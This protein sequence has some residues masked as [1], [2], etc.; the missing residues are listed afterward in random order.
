MQTSASTRLIRAFPLHPSQLRLGS[1]LSQSRTFFS[2]GLLR[3][4]DA[5]GE[6]NPLKKGRQAK[7]DPQTVESWF[8]GEGLPY[9]NPIPGKSNWLGGDIPYPDNPTFKPPPPLSDVVRSSIYNRYLEA[10]QP[11][12]SKSVSRTNDPSSQ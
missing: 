11:A 8:R 3:D 6:E 1:K 4:E 10:L 2:S 5:G 9:L 12:V 7:V